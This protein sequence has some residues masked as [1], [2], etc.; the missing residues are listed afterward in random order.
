MLGPGRRL[1]HQCLLLGFVQ[2][3]LVQQV[4]LRSPWPRPSAP[5]PPP[6]WSTA[7]PQHTLAGHHRKSPPCSSPAACPDPPSKGLLL[8]PASQDGAQWPWG[9]PGLLDARITSSC[10]C[11]P[12]SGSISRLFLGSEKS[13]LSFRSQH[14][15]Y[16]PPRQSPQGHSDPPT[17]EHTER[18]P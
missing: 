1:L 10:V 12:H 15:H 11:L 5:H 9:L 18:Q 3:V 7:T 14:K 6:P 13:T 16:S 4:K 2:G 8:P 17:L